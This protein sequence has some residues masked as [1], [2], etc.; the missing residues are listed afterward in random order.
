MFTPQNI[1][2]EKDFIDWVQFLF[3]LFTPDEIQKVLQMYPAPSTPDDLN[4]TRFATNGTGDPTAVTMSSWAMGHQQRANVRANN[5]R[6]LRILFSK[7]VPHVFLSLCP[8][9][10]LR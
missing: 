10:N 8:S 5:N 2:T 6:G 4:T 3:P 9:A 1:T 7:F